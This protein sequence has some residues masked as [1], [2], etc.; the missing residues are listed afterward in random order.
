[1]KLV[2]GL[3]ESAVTEALAAA[4]QAL[5]GAAPIR[6]ALTREA[7][8]HV[9]ARLLYD[10]AL[11]ALRAI[12]GEAQLEAQVLLANRL[13]EVL[14]EA[15]KDSGITRDDWVKQPA[16]LLLAIRREADR[17]LGSAD[18]VRPS[19]PLRHSDLLV[20]G[21]RDLRVGNEVRRE[22]ASA[23]RVDLLLSFVKWSGIRLLRDELREFVE[24]RPGGL[25]VLTTTYMGA[26]EA[27]ALEFLLD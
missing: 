13:L 8:P 6:E 11:K 23:D 19:L 3:Y 20:N 18:V 2:P 4:L 1:V 27:I 16:E 14:G 5:E 17:R 7:G 10:A 26:T 22:L 21:P 15:S 9:L 25:R 12:G 24:R